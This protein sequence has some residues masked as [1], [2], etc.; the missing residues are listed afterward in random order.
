MDI[1]EFD[2]NKLNT[3]KSLR[4]LICGKTLSG[5]SYLF[6]NIFKNFMQNNYSDIFVICPVGHSYQYQDFKKNI[7]TN[8]YILECNNY[9]TIIKALKYIKTQRL[10]N[11]VDIKN[12]K[13]IW[14]KNFFILFDDILNEKLAKE[15][16]FTEIFTNFRHFNIS[17]CFIGQY[18][19]KFIKFE[20]KA[21]LDY[22]FMLKNGSEALLYNKRVISD[23]NRLLLIDKNQ[24]SQVI[25]NIMRKYILNKK[26]GVLIFSNDENTLYYK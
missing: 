10:K 16:G 22:I 8:L 15:P 25:N 26:Y 4:L 13:K 17:V 9:K 20:Q 24:K 11:F 18:T 19:F 14:N 23:D 2:F 21:Q 1:K 6:L 7:K 3:L 12:N 5:K